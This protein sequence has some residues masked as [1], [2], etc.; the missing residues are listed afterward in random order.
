VRRERL[1]GDSG[2]HVSSPGPWCGPSRSRA[3]TQCR[4]CQPLAGGRRWWVSGCGRRPSGCVLRRPAVD[5]GP[6]G[7][8]RDRV[9]GPLTTRLA[10]A[11][12]GRPRGRRPIGRA[13]REWSL[14]SADG[15]ATHRHPWGG[16][17]RS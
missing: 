5:Q 9:V 4:A 11:D 6:P 16:V 17:G 3:Y 8:G 7:G 1:G 12:P 15:A 10:P 2:G 14:A 13:G